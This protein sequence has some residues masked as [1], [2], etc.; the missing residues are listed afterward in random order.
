MSCINLIRGPKTDIWCVCK[1]C[2]YASTTAGHHLPDFSVH[3]R[4]PSW[5]L[6]VCQSTPWTDR[7]NSSTCTVLPF[8]LIAVFTA[9]CNHE[10]EPAQNSFHYLCTLQRASP[11]TFVD[12]LFVLHLPYCRK[13]NQRPYMKVKYIEKF[14]SHFIILTR[15]FLLNCHK[16]K[17][18]GP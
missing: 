15:Y 12:N 18:Y 16:Y 13:T 8:R 3:H 17:P 7:K 2:A 14:S 5:D 4:I 10:L 11:V 1:S 9:K 6:Y